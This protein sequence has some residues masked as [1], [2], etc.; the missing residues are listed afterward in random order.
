MKV[1][2]ILIA[3]TTGT[4][5]MTLF[6]YMVSISENENFSE[7]ERLGQLI[8]NLYPVLN[9]KEKLFAGWAAHYMVGL[10]FAAIY[11]Q[12][13]EKKKLKPSFK[14]NLIT[15]GI[16]GIVAVGIWKLTFNAHPL[17]PRLSF[18]KYYLQLVPAHIVFSIFSGLAYRVLNKTEINALEK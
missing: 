14:N 7:P 11:V 3:G 6:S 5:F 17:P 2:E 4:S 18:N 9:K 16:S 12:L 8:H 10:I 15:G 13:W 1:K